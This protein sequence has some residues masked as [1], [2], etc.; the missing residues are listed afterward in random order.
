MKHHQNI[1]IQNLK[2]QLKSQATYKKYQMIPWGL[3]TLC[4]MR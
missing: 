4:Y 3:Y 2:P 1:E